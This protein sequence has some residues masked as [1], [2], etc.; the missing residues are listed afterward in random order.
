MSS[1]VVEGTVDEINWFEDCTDGSNVLEEKDDEGKVEVGFLDV[2]NKTLDNIA[3][4][5]LVDCIFCVG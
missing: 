5:F 2:E 1:F 3:D 4:V